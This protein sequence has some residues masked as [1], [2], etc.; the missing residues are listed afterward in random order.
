MYSINKGWKES[1]PAHP[2]FSRHKFSDPSTY[3]RWRNE[4][5]L[6]TES[7]FA[8]QAN[9]YI[10][11]TAPAEW[12]GAGTSVVVTGTIG[13]FVRNETLSSLSQ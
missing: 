3:A 2:W 8:L 13:R 7:E 9:I 5:E 12:A 1:A 11:A 6:E 4:D 10:S